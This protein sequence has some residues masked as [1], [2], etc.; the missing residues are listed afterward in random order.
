MFARLSPGAVNS[1]MLMK[2]LSTSSLDSI[3]SGCV[4]ISLALVL[5]LEFVQDYCC[6]GVAVAQTL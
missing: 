5:D 4:G 3:E 2:F 6:V 1:V